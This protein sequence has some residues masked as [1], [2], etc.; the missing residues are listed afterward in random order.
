M[1]VVRLY[2]RSWKKSPS[3]RAEFL[4]EFDYIKNPKIDGYRGIHLIYKYRSESEMHRQWS[5]LRIEIQIRSKLQHAWATAVETVDAFTGQGLKVSG[6]T[7][8]EKKD[9]GRFFALM[10]SAMALKEKTPLVPDTPTDEKQLLQELKD[11]ADRLRAIETL[12]GWSYTMTYLEDKAKSDDA[13][14]IIT[15]DTK[16]R[17]FNWLGF[18]KAEMKKAQETYLEKEKSIQGTPGVQVVLVSVD[19]MAAIRAAYPNYY[20]DTRE[21]VLALQ[22]A[23]DD[24][25]I[26]RVSEV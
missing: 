18:K 11:I 13:V 19:S 8:T 24:V 16:K 12:A 22:D 5:G 23:I 1:Q 9:W 3:T 6:G 4:K 14:F 2:R 15:L 17:V 26:N 10:S 7:G 20:A 21:F 25:K